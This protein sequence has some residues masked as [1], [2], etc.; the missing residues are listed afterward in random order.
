MQSLK[1]QKFLHTERRREQQV[2]LPIW[3]LLERLDTTW[4]SQL[5]K[6]L[7]NLS[8]HY[9]PFNLPV[10]GF[11]FTPDFWLDNTHS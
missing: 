10:N 11:L 2:K 4:K 6:E 8:Q 5:M 9:F 3:M 1:R 7:D